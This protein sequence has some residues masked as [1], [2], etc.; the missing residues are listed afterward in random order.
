VQ[1]AREAA[2]RTQCKN[3]FKQMSLAALNHA[4]TSDEQ[5][6]PL[7]H[8]LRQELGPRYFLLPYLEEN[9]MHDVFSPE[10][11][12][13]LAPMYGTKEPIL[14]GVAS[15]PTFRCASTP[16]DPASATALHWGDDEEGPFEAVGTAD[17]TVVV[18]VRELGKIRHETTYQG[19][20]YPRKSVSESG[21]A[22]LDQGYKAN[23]GAPLKFVVDGLSKTILFAEASGKPRVIA[24]HIAEGDVQ[25]AIHSTWIQS[26]L[27][28]FFFHATINVSNQIAVLQLSS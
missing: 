13:Q 27:D 16:G 8:P 7:E 19:A 20:W 4:S 3:Q 9:E 23:R 26:R 17:S 28:W 21:I 11:P 15:V 25:Y 14:T 1:A 12:W 6:P 10:R 24:P 18:I 2:R 5:L 22:Q